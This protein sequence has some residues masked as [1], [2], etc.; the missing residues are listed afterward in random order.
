LL[1]YARS[2]NTTLRI[3]RIATAIARYIQMLTC[4]R[5]RAA[6]RFPPGGES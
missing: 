2:M 5:S 4:G 6:A 3:T 1:R